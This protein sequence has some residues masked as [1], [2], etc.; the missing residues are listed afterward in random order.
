MAISILYN[1][2]GRNLKL[3]S[4]QDQAPWLVQACIAPVATLGE[5]TLLVLYVTLERNEGLNEVFEKLEKIS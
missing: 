4:F 5:M 2:A 1:R 3:R